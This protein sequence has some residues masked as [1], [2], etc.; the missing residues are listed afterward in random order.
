MDVAVENCLTRSGP[1]VDPNIKAFDASVRGGDI[2]A[3]FAEE[4]VDG[5]NFV[6]VQIEIRRNVAARQDQ[7]VQRGNGIQIPNG[8]DDIASRDLMRSTHPTK[9]AILDIFILS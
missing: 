7:R 8:K 6:A 1:G 2:G 5:E 3:Q 4:F 9:W